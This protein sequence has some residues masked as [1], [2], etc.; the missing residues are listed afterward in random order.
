MPNDV[1]LEELANPDSTVTIRGKTYNVLPID[2]FGMQLLSAVPSSDRMAMIR[3]MYKI[4]AKCIGLTFDEVFGT[5]TTVG[6]SE[7][8]VMA[9]AE[10]AQKHVKKVE[11]T[12]PNDSSA[13]ATTSG[14]ENPPHSP[15]SPQ[16]I[17]LAS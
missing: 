15:D 6:F 2:G 5:D 12:V 8:E 17:Q 11:A 7:S 10:V 9:I 13:G 14:T 3:T 1:T 16:P 4:A